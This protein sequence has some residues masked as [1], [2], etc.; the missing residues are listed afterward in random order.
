MSTLTK[1]HWVADGNRLSLSMPLTKVDQ[2]N[3]LVSGFATLDNVD[4]QGD[5][6]LAEASSQAFA[7]ARGNIREMHQPIA[8]G[9]VVDFREDEFYHDGEF[10]RGIYVTAYVS[11]GA[12][13][14]WEKVLD[15]TLTGFSIGG[16][17]IEASN[18]FVKE[19]GKSVR[20][21]KSYDLVELSLVDNPA[22]Q[23]ANVFSITK[24]ADGHTVVKGMAVEVEVE[25]VF[26]CATDEIFKSVAEESA[27]CANCGNEMKNIGWVE[28]GS[29]RAEKVRDV[30]T[31]FLGSNAANNEGEGGVENMGIR[32]ATDAEDKGAVNSTE[33]T[34]GSDEAKTPLEE[35]KE[36]AKT[37]N[38]ENKVDDEADKAEALDEVDHS[39]ENTPADEHDLGEE[40]KANAVDE[41]P[42]ADEEIGKKIDSFKEAVQASLE[43]TRS[44]TSEAVAALEK[45]LEENAQSFL[46]KVSDLESKFS[47]FG[48]DLKTA[49]AKQA[50][51]EKSLDTLNSEGSFK[52]SGDV[53]ND[54]KPEQV[55]KA[56]AWAGAFSIDNLLK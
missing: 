31:K 30:V 3:R 25:N 18:E 50:E 10:Y 54:E 33:V 9:K 8:V 4:S 40:A 46:S 51:L 20:F 47:E 21:I 49:K 43:K 12:E 29:D 37:D 48:E 11:K 5:V 19:Q 32:K 22:N 6:V 56:N 34:E 7:R 44:E 38:V 17:I 1:S 28:T 16:N 26:Y 42:D 14:T 2:E 23:L 41:T 15:G 36:E 27:N 39:D 24:A 53:G 45:K 52:K 35:L 13:G 55:Q